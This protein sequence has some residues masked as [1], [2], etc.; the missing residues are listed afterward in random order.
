MYIEAMTLTLPT[1]RALT[2]CLCIIAMLA[3]SLASGMRLSL[4]AEFFATRSMQQ[5]S[6]TD[7]PAERHK[8]CPFG[9]H[10]QSFG[11]CLS[12]SLVGLAQSAADQATLAEPR[13]SH[14]ALTP[15]AALTK[16][17]ASRL[18]R[19]PRS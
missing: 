14:F 8:N 13:S 2:I 18:E 3:M 12:I 11:T 6:S 9:D 7:G 16:I 19:P 1:R 17:Y 15:S 4:A 10:T 5:I